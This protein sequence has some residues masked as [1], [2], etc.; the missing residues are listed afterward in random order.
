MAYQQA[1]SK[2]D[3]FYLRKFEGALS[4]KVKQTLYYFTMSEN[5]WKGQPCD[6]PTNKTVSENPKT[7]VLFLKNK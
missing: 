5:T 3:V 7:G 2:G 1:N 4:N 6:L